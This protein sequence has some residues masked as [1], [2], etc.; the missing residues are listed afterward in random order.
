M[1][2]YNQVLFI[3]SHFQPEM[4]W[5]G[6]FENQCCDEKFHYRSRNWPRL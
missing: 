4:E 5:N 2:F 6:G 3:F 1:H